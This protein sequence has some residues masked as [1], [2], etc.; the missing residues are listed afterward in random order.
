MCIYICMLES[1]V[2]TLVF[3]FFEIKIFVVGMCI[4][5][6]FILW[7]ICRLQTTYTTGVIY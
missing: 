3:M 1:C 6:W 7:I 4:T 2:H 5:M